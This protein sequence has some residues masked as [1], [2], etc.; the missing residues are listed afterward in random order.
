MKKWRILSRK[1]VM[2]DRWIDVE[3]SVCELEDGTR[4]EPYYVS[5]ARDFA[6]VVPV[7]EEGEMVLVRQYRHGI[8]EILLELPAGTMEPGE[9]PEEVAKRELEEETGYHAD[10]LEF[11][12]RTAPNA[13]NTSNFAWCYLARNVKWKCEQRL[14]ETEDV[15]VV[16]LPLKTVWELLE[17]GGFVQAVHVAA[18]YR[19]KELLLDEKY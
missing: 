2:K 13:S 15:E 16:K 4:I 14:D 9:T 7:T 10:S 12:F 17:Q 8:Q 3:A 5:H 19:A 18:L 1:T 11:L 6:V